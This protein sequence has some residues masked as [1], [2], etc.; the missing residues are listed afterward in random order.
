MM[1]STRSAQAAAPNNGTLSGTWRG[2]KRKLS[3]TRLEGKDT[4]ATRTGHADGAKTKT[5]SLQ[6][7]LA[8]AAETAARKPPS[9]FKP[10]AVPAQP[11]PSVPVVEG[12]VPKGASILI[13]QDP[14][15]SLI[16]DGHKTWEIRGQKCNKAP[17]E[18]IYLALSGAGGVILGSA[19][20]AVS[21]GP[22]SPDEFSSARARH[23][24]AGESLPYGS[25]YAWELKCPVRFRSPVRYTPEQGQVVWAH[26]R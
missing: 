4:V 11:L 2:T 15:I 9:K 6:E 20:F 8:A 12:V 23:C 19:T 16:L 24:V 5:I 14:W 3:D 13:I 1:R 25:T 18:T 22:L 26:Y 10:V 21:H 17:G 7:A